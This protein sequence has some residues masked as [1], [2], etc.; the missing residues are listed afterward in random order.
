[1]RY[2]FI[3]TNIFLYMCM[4]FHFFSCQSQKPPNTVNS[5]PLNEI[6]ITEI[7][8]SYDNGSFT[9]REIVELYL[10]YVM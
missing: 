2:A 5:F 9:V 7:Q 1:M 10:L 8:N 4:A 3:P 6:T